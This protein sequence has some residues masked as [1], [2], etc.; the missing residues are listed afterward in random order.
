MNNEI[1]IFACYTLLFYS[2]R[3]LIKLGMLDISLLNAKSFCRNPWMVNSEANVLWH[4]QTRAAE[5]VL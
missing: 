3:D 1:H 5:A 2:H 4:P